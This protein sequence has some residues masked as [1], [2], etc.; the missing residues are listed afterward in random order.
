M[1]M[2]PDALLHT[3]VSGFQASPVG[4][5]VVGTIRRHFGVE[6][7][8]IGGPPMTLVAIA[9]QLLDRLIP[10]RKDEQVSWDRC[11]AVDALSQTGRWLHLLVRSDATV[12]F[13]IDIVSIVIGY[14]APVDEFAIRGNGYEVKPITWENPAP[15]PAATAD[16]LT[17]ATPSVPTRSVMASSMACAMTAAAIAATRS[18]RHGNS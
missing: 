18:M 4:A 15:F 7:D 16:P 2:L 17:Q 1:R 14:P 13:I 11:L 6:A 3:V 5:K 12:P 9:L 10:I 8:L